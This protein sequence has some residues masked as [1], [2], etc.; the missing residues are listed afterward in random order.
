[1]T[2]E[3]EGVVSPHAGVHLVKATFPFNGTDDDEVCK[4]LSPSHP[5]SLPAYENE[6]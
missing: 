2:E 5:S 3:K 4:F 1:M 6:I